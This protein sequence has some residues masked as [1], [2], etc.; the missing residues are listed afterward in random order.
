[1][2]SIGNG[3]F[4]ACTSLISVNIPNSV[5]SIGNGA[6]SDCTSLTSI[7]IPNSVTSIG[8]GAFSDCTNLTI[9][10][11][12]GSYADTYAKE[13]NIP[14]M[15]TEISSD[16]Y[17][18]KTQIETG[19]AQLSNSIDTKIAEA[20]SIIPK[21]YIVSELPTTNIDEN[22]TYLVPANE[23][24]TDNI[25]TEY[26]YIN[27][28]WEI[29]GSPFEVDLSGYATQNDLI[30]SHDS[31][32]SEIESGLTDLSNEI[33]TELNT[34]ENRI[35][36]DTV[37]DTE[38]SACFNNNVQ[39]RLGELTS[40][41]LNLPDNISDDYISSVIFTS[42]ATATNLIYPD[43]IKMLGEDCIDCIFTPAA[44]KRYEVIVSYDGV[45][46]VGVVG[47]YAV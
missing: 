42:G 21:R 35:S 40:L 18:T 33:Y 11:E 38:Y 45:N 4:S 44:N 47:G 19:L 9:Y 36:I 6:F 22:G 30:Q 34:K 27:N 17:A 2:T 1:M 25:Y 16:T 7:N 5:T 20:K 3:A 32:H 13:S 31:L 10:C 14:I 12:Q 46:V 8:N 24:N 26:A 43:T 29:I 39:Y 28:A 41:T 23:P 15:Y 37:S